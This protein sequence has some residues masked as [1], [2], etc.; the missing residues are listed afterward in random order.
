MTWQRGDGFGYVCTQRTGLMKTFTLPSDCKYT[1][2]DEFIKQFREDALGAANPGPVPAVHPT[3]CGQKQLSISSF[4]IGDTNQ[5]QALLNSGSWMWF[6]CNGPVHWCARC[7]CS[8]APNCF[9]VRYVGGF[10][11][12]WEG[13]FSM[14]SEVCLFV[15]L[16][17]V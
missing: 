15:S 3:H 1:K 9:G 4:F 11:S 7:S 17:Q 8:S 16:M 6:L 5:H 2:K 10:R 14:I 13:G 12:I